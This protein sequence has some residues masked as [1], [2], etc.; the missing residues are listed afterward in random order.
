M[1][2]TEPR[3]MSFRVLEYFVVT[4]EKNGTLLYREGPFAYH[5]DAF[6]AMQRYDAS[7]V[8]VIQIVGLR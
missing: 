1:E 2:K 3:K 7:T 4:E 8:L 6:K 5:G